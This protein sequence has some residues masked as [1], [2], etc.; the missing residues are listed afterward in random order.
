RQSVAAP[1]WADCFELL[2]LFV[3]APSHRA[4]TGNIEENKAVEDSQLA[5]VNCR[6]ELWSALKFPVKLEISHSHFAAAD[7]SRRA[8]F[9][10]QHH[11]HPSQ[12]FDNAAK[13][14]LRPGC[15]LKLGKHPQNFLGTVERKHK[16]R[17]D[18]QQGVSKVRVFCEP[19]HNSLSNH[20]ISRLLSSRNL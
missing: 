20:G 7:K 2:V 12:E 4:S 18:A 5:F 10:P 11:R 15:R 9:K 17:H 19:F 3:Q 13:P 16:S 8:R 1:Y 14:E 6:K